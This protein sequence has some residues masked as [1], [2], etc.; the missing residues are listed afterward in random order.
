MRIAITSDIHYHPPWRPRM[1][2]LVTTIQA[3]EPD[4]LVLAGDIGEP[5]E[6]FETGLEIFAPA[7]ENRAVI[8]GNHDLWHR[9]SDNTS[10]MLWEELLPK[11]A[12]K[13]G[14][15]WLEYRNLILGSLGVCGTIAW[16]D[17]SG[18]HPDL[19]LD[20]NTY[21][22]LKSSISNDGRFVDLPWTDREFAGRVGADFGQR[23]KALQQSEDVQDI[24]VVTHVPLF[25]QSLRSYDTPQDAVANAYYANLPLGIEALKVEKVSAVFSGH[26]HIDRCYKVE[27]EAGDPVLVMNIPSDYGAPA[28]VIW[29]STT[30]EATTIRTYGTR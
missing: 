13:H 21:E 24:V 10:Q 7:C 28:V 30:G 22:Q 6:L 17:Y 8:A 1:D 15:H 2:R 12:F 16:Y 9:V 27:R 5:L 3:L 23:L 19:D 20:E 25:R 26:V 11:T 18:R 4:L 14:Y 29:D